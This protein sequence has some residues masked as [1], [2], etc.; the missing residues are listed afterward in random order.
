MPNRILK[1][2]ICVSES[3][4][5]LLPMEE[6]I[7]YRLLVNCDDFGR[8]DGRT[9]ILLAKLFPLRAVEGGQMVSALR[10]MEALGMICRYEAG[11]RP[12]LR[13]VNWEAHQSVRAKRSKY[14]PPEGAGG[15]LGK[16]A[17]EP[18]VFVPEADAAVPKADENGQEAAPIAAQADSGRGGGK[19]GKG[20]KRSMPKGGK[21]APPAGKP[22]PVKRQA[23]HKKGIKSAP[24][25]QNACAPPKPDDACNQLQA[26]ASK[27][28][29]VN[30]DASNCKQV[31]ANASICARNPI[32]IRIQS[33]SESVSVSGAAAADAAADKPREGLALVEE[34]AA[35]MG[36][37]FAGADRG[38]AKGL[39]EEYTLDWLLEAMR[40]AAEGQASCRSWRYIR[41][42]LK[43]WRAKGGIDHVHGGGHQAGEQPGLAGAEGEVRAALLIR[44]Y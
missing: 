33:E 21:A 6:V 34:R 32:R 4:E 29:Q 23:L 10:H 25:P 1:E 11:G 36:M 30:A 17:E 26:D 9:P 19:A 22:R 2:T 44:R 31:H 43:A 42:I 12:Y 18:D 14:P 41:A 13:V 8:M 35:A 39:M 24:V 27:C 20:A 40:R 7:F 37:V 3:I 28:M 15:T 5:A 16:D 38:L